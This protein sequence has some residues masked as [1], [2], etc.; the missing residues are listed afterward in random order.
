MRRIAIICLLPLAGCVN[1]SS[2]EFAKKSE[3]ACLSYGF[4]PGSDQMAN[5][6]MNLALIQEQDNMR[7]KQNMARA[8]NDFGDDMQRQADRNT[9]LASTLQQPPVAP[10]YTRRPVVSC[11]SRPGLGTIET[12]CR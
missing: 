3:Q 7:R 2:P 5:C 10:I 12:T 9:Y 1:T 4:K 11:T 8:L 6:R